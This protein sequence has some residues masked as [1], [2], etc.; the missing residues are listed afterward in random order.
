MILFKVKAGAL[1][2]TMF[3]VVVIALLLAAFVILM[4]THKRFKLQTSFVKETTRNADRGIQYALENKIINNDTTT[5]NIQDEDY[6]SLKIYCDYWGVFEKVTSKSIIKNNQFNKIAL[7]GSS[8]PQL[9]RTALYIKDN[10]KPLVLVGNTKIQ[11]VSYLPKQGVRTGN[12]AGHSYYG[13]SLIYGKERLSKSLPK[14]DSE[15]IKTIKA[16]DEIY[17]G[18]DLDQFLELSQKRNYQNSFFSPLKVIYSK[19]TIN[20]S[21]LNLTGHISVQS[22]TK[23]IVNPSSD[24]KDVV[25]VAP[26]IEIKNNVT[27]TFQAFATKEITV[28]NHCKLNYPSAL[29][30]N[31][32]KSF[33]QLNTNAN[34]NVKSSPF[35]KINKGSIVK[36]VI[37]Y[38]GTTKNYQSQIFIDED[39]TIT[40]EVYCNKNLELLGTV[41]GSVFA[42]GFVAVQSGSVY[43]NHIY[44]GTIIVDNLPQEYTGL[45]LENSKKG[46]AKWLY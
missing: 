43:Q 36:G 46:V 35:V 9:D 41:Y 20:L 13:Q 2:L 4:H 42:S 16:I 17:Q 6:K 11:G 3:V 45:L 23:I 14:F 19:E 8:Q 24:L 31:E 33:N 44:N 1:Q 30:L 37:A 27:G 21:D 18:V 32:D 7:V 15:I 28:G 40:G 38:L 39:V 10:N 12:I 22:E 26:K 25:L 5:V 29:I 34:S